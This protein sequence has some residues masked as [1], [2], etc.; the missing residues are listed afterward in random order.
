MVRTR[1]SLAKYADQLLSEGR[2]VFTAAEAENELGV[3]HRSFLDAAE[4]LQRSRKLL[5][6]RQAFYVVVP[7]QFAS[8]GAPPPTWFIDALMRSEGG[9]PVLVGDR[10]PTLAGP[11]RHHRRMRVFAGSYIGRA[12]TSAGMRSPATSMLKPPSGGSG[13]LAVSTYPRPMAPPRVWP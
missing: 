10:L 1:Q 6:P 3:G 8:W 13:A 2:S 5:T 11:S 7:P 12:E 9:G 4:R